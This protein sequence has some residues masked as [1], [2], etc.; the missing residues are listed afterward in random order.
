MNTW[1]IL[2]FPYFTGKEKFISHSSSIFYSIQTAEGWGGKAN[3]A[4]ADKKELLLFWFCHSAGNLWGTS[5]SARFPPTLLHT[6]EPSECPA[7]C[8]W[9]KLHR[10]R[11]GEGRE[12]LRRGCSVCVAGGWHLGCS[13][14]SEAPVVTASLGGLSL[15]TADLCHNTGATLANASSSSAPQSLGKENFSGPQASC[16]SVLQTSLGVLFL[17]G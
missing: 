9:W 5:S 13:L 1:S 16:S 10:D 4:H 12:A 7:W 8:E 11:A 2:L 6:G 15:A 14:Q 17:H 3:G